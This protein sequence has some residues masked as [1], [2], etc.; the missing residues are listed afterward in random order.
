[1]ALG[2]E[3][4]L[5]MKCFAAREK[6]V[7]HARALLKRNPDRGLVERQ[8]QSLADRRIPGAQDALD[9]YD[10]LVEAT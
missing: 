7:G 3:D 9:F 4:L 6:D 5:V 1:M 2:V 10:D 8:L